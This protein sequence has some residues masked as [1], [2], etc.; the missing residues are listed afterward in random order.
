MRCGAVRTTAAPVAGGKGGE[1]L[2]GLALGL[3]AP[4]VDLVEVPH[5]GP[6]LPLDA[7]E[8][9]DGVDGDDGG[10]D[11]ALVV[12][13]RAVDVVA[14][15][16]QAVAVAAVVAEALRARDEDRLVV[17]HLGT[18]QPAFVRVRVRSCVC[19]CVCVC[20]RVKQGK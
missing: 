9:D 19:V 15:E 5:D 6:L 13:R 16:G 8:G 7:A 4:A 1:D 14:A 11:A 12:P 2:A 3:P 17:V 20:G 10:H 18:E